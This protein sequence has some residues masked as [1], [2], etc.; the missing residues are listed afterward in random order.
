MPQSYYL[1]IKALAVAFIEGVMEWE[2]IKP[3]VRK[4]HKKWKL[5][6]AR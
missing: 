6:N 1:L 2:E 4:I 5:Q 3:L